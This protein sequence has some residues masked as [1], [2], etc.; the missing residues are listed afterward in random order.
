MHVDTNEDKIEH[1]RKAIAPELGDW[2]LFANGTFVVFEDAAADDDL[3]QR[4]IELLRTRGEVIPGTASADF[5]VTSLE[6]TTGWVV[7]GNVPGMY[8][9]VKPEELDSDTPGD[10]EIG[11]FA[12]TIRQLDHEDLEVMHINRRSE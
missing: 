1:V 4:A 7:R 9:Y 11:M 5:Q 3:G 2:V 6:H 12:R 8:V 10:I